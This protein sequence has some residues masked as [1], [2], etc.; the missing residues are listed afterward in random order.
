MNRI[1]KECKIEMKEDF[2]E[3]GWGKFI[4]RR[5]A[6]AIFFG[7][8]SKIKT[9]VCPNCGYIEFIAKKPEIFK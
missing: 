9:L 2:I 4:H 8:Q 1:C 5:D 3:S 6:I 7:K